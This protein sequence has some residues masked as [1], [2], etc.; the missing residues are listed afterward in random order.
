MRTIGTIILALI[1]TY[2]IATAQDTLYIYKS[3]TVVSKRAIAQIDSV[4]FKAPTLTVQVPVVTTNAVSAI[5]ETTATCGGNI[6]TSGGATITARG[7]CWSTSANPTIASSKTTEGAGAGSFTS[8]ITDL[9]SNTTYYVRAYATNS[10]GIGYGSPISFTTQKIVSNTVTDIDGNVYHTVTIG[11]QVWMVE[12]LKTTK[13]RN[14][15]PIPNV[16]DNTSW[17]Q[18]MTGAYCNYN[19]DA[20]I[21]AKY[22]KLYNWYAVADS[23]NIAPT[24]WHVPTDAEWST[25]ET[26][27]QANSGTSGSVAKALASKTDWDSSTNGRAIGN[28]LTKNNT[29]CFTALPGGYRY[30]GSFYNMGGHGYWWSSTAGYTGDAW[31]MELEYCYSIMSRFN[32]YRNCGFSVRCV[33]DL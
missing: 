11:S 2:N 28:D 4:T 1:L 32:Y 22:G 31:S 6:T 5:T 12:N 33:R 17:V 3:G 16:T 7:V 20:A 13:Y 30:D 24:G 21:G 27:V 29:S 8:A 15:S 9:T 23:R 25:L 18:I 26:Y 19:N 10:A 14:G